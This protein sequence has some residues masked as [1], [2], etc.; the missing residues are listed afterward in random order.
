MSKQNAIYKKLMAVREAVAAIRQ[1]KKNPHF[2]SDYADINDVLA[3]VVP[4]CRAQGLVILQPIE[5]GNV[6]TRIVDVETGDEVTSSMPLTAGLPAQKAGSEVTYFRRYTLVSLLALEQTDD[7]GN[8][9]TSAKPV[10]RLTPEQMEATAALPAEKL[11]AAIKRAESQN[12][13]QDQI[14]ELKKLLA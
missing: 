10:K 9:A 3:V 11:S 4:E 8:A 2:K 6:T 13:A 7:D 12:V 5:N 1:T 14:A